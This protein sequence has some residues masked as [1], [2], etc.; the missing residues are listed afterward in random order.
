MDS[1]LLAPPRIEDAADPL[2]DALAQ[3]IDRDYEL[4]RSS[5][6][7]GLT[8][9]GSVMGTPHCMSPE[10]ASAEPVIDGR[11]YLYS[12]GV[13]AQEMLA[14]RLPFDGKTMREV[15]VK[16]VTAAPAPLSTT[17]RAPA[18]S[19]S[20]GTAPRTWCSRR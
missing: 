3:A 5:A 8:Q 13:V 7:T 14:G 12:L 6:A 9:A 19:T 10:Q 11:R 17:T 18:S 1:A 2:R 20:S 15:M 16:H 4:L